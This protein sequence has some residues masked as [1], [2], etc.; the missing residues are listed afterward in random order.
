M[1]AQS[2]LILYNNINVHNYDNYMRN[3]YRALVSAAG[4]ADRQG[5]E[6][7]EVVINIE[8]ARLIRTCLAPQQRLRAGILRMIIGNQNA[9]GAVGSVMSYLAGIL[10]WAEMDSIMLIF[11]TLIAEISSPDCRPDR[12][13]AVGQFITTS[14]CENGLVI[15]LAN[16]HLMAT[17][18][19][20]TALIPDRIRFLTEVL[21]GG[22]EQDTRHGQGVRPTAPPPA[23]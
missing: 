1:V 13:G 18:R 7:C 12:C 10:E 23:R 5:D 6:R 22:Q 19:A 15:E 14:T 11:D 8:I 4:F 3:R 20:N 16:R 21:R 17:Q 9:P 2:L